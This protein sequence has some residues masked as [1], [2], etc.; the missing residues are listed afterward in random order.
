MD[1]LNERGTSRTVIRNRTTDVEAEKEV[2]RLIRRKYRDLGPMT[3]HEGAVLVLF[4]VLV[5]VWFFRDPQF[6]PGWSEFIP[7]A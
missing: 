1:P 7:G 5:L 4:V 2:G 3:F 6:I